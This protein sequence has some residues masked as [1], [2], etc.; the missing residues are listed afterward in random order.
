MTIF[1][2]RRLQQWKP[3]HMRT[4][5]KRRCHFCASGPHRVGR[6]IQVLES[7]MRYYFCKETCLLSWQQTRH[8]ADVV[9]WLRMCTGERAKIQQR[10]RDEQAEAD[11][12]GTPPCVRDVDHRKVSVPTSA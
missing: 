5:P 8:D 12:R 1:M 4:T 10:V 11:H 7:P 3:E 2:P 6:L 9:E